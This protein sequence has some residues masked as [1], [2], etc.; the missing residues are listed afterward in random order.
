MHVANEKF[1]R[2]ENDTDVPPIYKGHISFTK[3]KTI[4]S[5]VQDIKALDFF[6]VSCF[7]VPFNNNG[8]SPNVYYCSREKM[9][10]THLIEQLSKADDSDQLMPLPG[11][12]ISADNLAKA[13]YFTILADLGQTDSGPNILDNAELLAHST[14]DY[15]AIRDRTPIWGDNLRV[16]TTEGWKLRE[17]LLD[18][19]EEIVESGKQF[20]SYELLGG[21][22][23]ESEPAESVQKCGNCCYQTVKGVPVVYFKA[24]FTPETEAMILRALIA[25]SVPSSVFVSHAKTQD[26]IKPWESG[27]VTLLGDAAHS[28][29]P[30]L[31]KGASSAI[32]G[33]MSLAKA[34]KSE[35]KQ[36]QGD[37]LKAQVSIYEGAKLNHGFEAARQSMTTQRFTFNT[38]DTPW[39]CWLRKLALK[40]WDWWMSH[41]PAIKE[42]FPVNYSEMKKGV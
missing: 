21:E 7:F 12:W 8:V 15:K 39:K 23:G 27:R 1:F 24:P 35:P 5:S 40:A 37:S 3:R 33:A 13:F 6:Q 22:S 9:N 25:L 20:S 2:R 34:L 29:T 10:N 28:M 32:I 14:K 31:G 18:G 38:G 11:I 41:P 4:V 42:D 26:P 16:N 36:G 30:Y 17:A 19:A